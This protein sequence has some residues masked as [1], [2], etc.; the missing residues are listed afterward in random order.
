MRRRFGSA[1][2]ATLVALACGDSTSPDLSGAYRFQASATGSIVVLQI[3]SAAIRDTAES[4]RQS[5]TQRWVVGT[6]RRGN[7]GINAPWGWH[8]DPA[9]IAFPEITIEACQATPEY[10][11]QTLDYWITFGQVC[12]SGFV[13]APVE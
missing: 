6:I 9:T 7:G 11:E 2:V 5:H 1:I 12:I 3:S 13:I 4:L 10:I 8:L